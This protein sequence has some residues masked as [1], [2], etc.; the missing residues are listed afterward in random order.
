[1]NARVREAWAATKL[2]VWPGRYR[3][4]SLPVERLAE[5]AAVLAGET[6]YGA[7]VLERDEVSL[8]LDERRWARHPLRPAARSEAGPYRAVTLDVNLDLGLTGYLAPAAARLA[9]AGVS[10]LPQCAF[11]KDHLL[12]REEDLERAVAVL[13]NLVSEASAGAGL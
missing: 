11:L 6:G 4:V 13:E 9:Q 8:T 1:V 7:L 10:I 12:V 3:L 5:A 2:H